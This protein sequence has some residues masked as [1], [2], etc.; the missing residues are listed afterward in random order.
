MPALPASRFPLDTGQ[1]TRRGFLAAGIAGGFALAARDQSDTHAQ[2]TPVINTSS[3]GADVIPYSSN[4]E[5]PNPMRGQYE[6]LLVAEYWHGTSY[7]GTD[8]YQRYVWADIHTG[9]NTFDFSQI[10][11]DMAAAAAAGKRFGMA[12]MMADYPFRFDA[13]PTWATQVPGATINT[14][15]SAGTAVYPNWNNPAYLSMVQTLINALAAQFDLDERLA[16][17]EVSG[18]GDWSQWMCYYEVYYYG[19]SAPSPADTVSEL[20]YH[21]SSTCDVITMA[22]ITTLIGYHVA[23]FKNTRLVIKSN[24]PEAVRQMLLGTN[25][26]GHPTAASTVPAIPPG[27]RNDGLG[28]ESPVPFQMWG[29]PGEYYNG[30]ALN[31]AYLNNYTKGPFITEWYEVYSGGQNSTTYLATALQQTVNY[32]A[33]MVGSCN[34]PTIKSGLSSSDYEIW[35]RICMYSGYRYSASSSVAGDNVRVTWTNWGVAP[36]YDKWQLIYQVRNSSNT[37]VQTVNSTYCFLTLGAANYG[38]SYNWSGYSPGVTA[39]S[40][41]VGE[42][43]PVTGSDSFTL[44]SLPEG[45]Y[46]VWVQVAWNQHKPGA[47]YT[48]NYPPMAL[49]M[50]GR[51]GTGAY[52]IGSFTH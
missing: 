15:G 8:N 28:T 23:A 17:F 22:N 6:D 19:L 21:T 43:T 30:K 38:P 35:L 31:S 24:N 4:V 50:N 3:G 40:T 37:I 2:S 14:T 32:N 9:P 51:D 25:F 48:F 16:Y 41:P 39:T 49:A 27:I 46:T 1:L 42:P 29:Y 45:S 34:N 7:A 26:A 11:T 10:Q 20:G 36:T 12:I 44:S 13:V 47:T 52:Q 18:Y 5:L 33:S